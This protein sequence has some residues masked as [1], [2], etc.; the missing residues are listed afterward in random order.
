MILRIA[1]PKDAASIAGIY[2]PSVRDSAIS[3]E[4]VPPTPNEMAERIKH[5]L[6]NYPWLVAE[7]DG[8][9]IGYACATP[10]RTRSAYRWSCETSIYVSESAH[11]KG[12]AK[13]LYL[14]LFDVLARLGYAN[15][16]A[17]IT[18]PNDPSVKFHEH[19]GFELIGVYKNI[20]FKSGQWQDVG[21]WNLPLQKLGDTPSDPLAFSEHRHAFIED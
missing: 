6:R 19:M 2:A 21:W 14:K 12:T 13:R 4:D 1:T 16:L 3:F 17:G 15:A 9:V 11:R 5:T 20:G 7:R 18:L 8:N 10:H